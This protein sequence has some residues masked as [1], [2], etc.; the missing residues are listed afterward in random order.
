MQTSRRAWAR[1]ALHPSPNGWSH[2]PMPALLQYII[3]L[4][5]GGCV[6]GG[7]CVPLGEAAGM[8]WWVGECAL[9]TGSAVPQMPHASQCSAPSQHHDGP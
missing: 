3:G 8:D 9:P 1:R 4:W 6:G 2:P 7:G 5:R